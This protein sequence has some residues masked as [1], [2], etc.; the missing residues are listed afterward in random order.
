MGWVCRLSQGDILRYLLD[1]DIITPDYILPDSSSLLHYL[2]GTDAEI[3]DLI[4]RG[5]SFDHPNE[6]GET[7]LHRAAHFA[8]LEKL[9]ILVARGFGLNT[10]DE[11]GYSPLDFADYYDFKRRQ[12]RDWLRERGALYGRRIQLERP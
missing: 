9:R 6:R 1:Q 11:E 2:D 10:L 7:P 8:C 3:E 4:E 5:L 12:C